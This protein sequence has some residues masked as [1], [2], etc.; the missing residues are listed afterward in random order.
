LSSTAPPSASPE[1]TPRVVT[2]NR[3]RVG[4]LDVL[5]REV[6]DPSS[7]THHFEAF[8]ELG[9]PNNLSYFFNSCNDHSRQDFITVVESFAPIS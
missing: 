6:T 2:E 5:I 7:S 8:V 1:S 3:Q 4:S 9:G